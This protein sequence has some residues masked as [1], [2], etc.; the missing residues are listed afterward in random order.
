MFPSVCVCVRAR[1]CVGEC[2][3]ARVSVCVCARVRVC[4][5]VWGGVCGGVCIV[6]LRMTRQS[7]TFRHVF[8][9]RRSR[10]ARCPI[11]Q[12]ERTFTAHKH[13]VCVCVSV[14]VTE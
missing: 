9:F 3:C 11:T 13:S 1:V 12:Q 6:C 7:V 10:A 8:L 5:R 2:V 4:A 14:C